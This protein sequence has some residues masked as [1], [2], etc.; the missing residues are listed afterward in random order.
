[1]IVS[2]RKVFRVIDEIVAQI[3]EA[4]F[5]VSTISDICF[6]GFLFS[7]RSQKFVNNVERA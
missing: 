5:V 7:R 2:L 4:K 1:M 3:V 6:V